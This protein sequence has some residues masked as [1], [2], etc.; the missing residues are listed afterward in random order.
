M[1]LNGT[2]ISSRYAYLSVAVVSV[3]VAVAVASVVTDA[4]R[5]F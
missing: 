3:V 4:P 5:G 1:N 2:T